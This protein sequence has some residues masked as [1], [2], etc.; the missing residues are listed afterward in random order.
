MRL[1]GYELMRPRPNLLRNF[2]LDLG[3]R[4][5]IA[6]MNPLIFKYKR[7]QRSKFTSKTVTFIQ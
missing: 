5:K 1:C 3:V 2:I 7:V 4:N 6:V